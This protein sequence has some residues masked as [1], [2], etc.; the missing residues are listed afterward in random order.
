MVSVAFL[1][2]PKKCEIPCRSS[3]VT[4][5]KQM[6][7]GSRGSGSHRGGSLEEI[8]VGEGVGDPWV[9]PL[10]AMLLCLAV[11]IS[12]RKATKLEGHSYGKSYK[13]SRPVR[14]ESRE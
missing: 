12:L 11:M 6:T 8:E 2:P 4:L 5:A 3:A 10:V 7:S 14:D 1:F 13:K 9:D